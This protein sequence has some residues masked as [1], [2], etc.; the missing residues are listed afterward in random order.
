MIYKIYQ[1]GKEVNGELSFDLMR[2]EGVGVF[3]SMRAYGVRILHEEE[4]LT[5][6]LESAKT[7]GYK[8]VPKIQKL[9]SFKLND[10]RKRIY[11]PKKD[12]P[13]SVLGGTFSIQQLPNRRNAPW[14]QEM[15]A[16]CRS[17]RRERVT[18]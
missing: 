2:T 10:A 1:N 5:R 6:L 9:Q 11:I 18:V 15:S 7:V 17:L 12:N 4:H 3:E 14:V 16:F 8:P 13:H